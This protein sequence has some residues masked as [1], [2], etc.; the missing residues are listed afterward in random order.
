MDP[1]KNEQP[2]RTKRG[3][4]RNNTVDNP[5]VTYDVTDTEL[6][7][8]GESDQLMDTQPNYGHPLHYRNRACEHGVEGVEPRYSDI[9]VQL[10]LFACAV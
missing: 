6:D 7:E 10:L 4:H 3:G 9:F 1:R 8:V 2:K 5:Y